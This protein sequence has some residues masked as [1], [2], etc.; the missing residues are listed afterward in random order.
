MPTFLDILDL[1]EI[2]KNEFRGDSIRSTRPRIFG[3]QLIAQALVAAQRTAGHLRVYSTQSSFAIPGEIT[4]PINFEVERTMDGRRFLVRRVIA[5][6]RS[7]TIF[8]MTASFHASED[9]LGHQAAIP[10]VPKPGSLLPETELFE[11]SARPLPLPMQRYLSY[12]R[13]FEIR[14]VEAARFFPEVGSRASQAFWMKGLDRLPD[15]RMIHDA[16]I[17]YMS[18]TTLM[19]TALMPHGKSIF[20]EGV[21]SA[22]LTHSLHFHMPA[23][24]DEWLLYTQQSTYAGG[25]LGFVSGQIFSEQGALV[26]SI[27]QDG[28]IRTSVKH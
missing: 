9:G 6:Q 19:D 3:G 28:L 10:S 22:S 17:A 5:K 2:S 4:E 23:R 8:S 24:A 11:K 20:H 26:A 27:A 7:G 1:E 14:P 15:A 21:E 13:P 12:D 25:A 18:D 16:M